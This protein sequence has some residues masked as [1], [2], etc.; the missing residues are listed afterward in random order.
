MPPMTEK[1]EGKKP[2]PRARICWIFVIFLPE[3]ARKLLEMA[4]EMAPTSRSKFVLFSRAVPFV[5]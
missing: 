5:V 4:I 2:S 1:R 3:I